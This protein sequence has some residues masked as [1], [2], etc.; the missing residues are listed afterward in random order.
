MIRQAL[1]H[2]LLR[3]NYASK[4]SDLA[5]GGEIFISENVCQKLSTCYKYNWINIAKVDKIYEGYVIKE[6]T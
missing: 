1:I 4:Y 6:F 3:N 2:F 5:A